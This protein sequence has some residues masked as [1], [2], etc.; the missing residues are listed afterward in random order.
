MYMPEHIR[1]EGALRIPSI[2]P[3]RPV[4]EVLE[5]LVGE[6]DL[7][8][9]DSGA[10]EDGLGAVVNVEAAVDGLG[11]IADRS[12]GLGLHVAVL[13]V[14]ADEVRSP[15][16]DRPAK[17]LGTVSSDVGDNELLVH[18]LLTGLGVAL[19]DGEGGRVAGN[20]VTASRRSGVG[21]ARNRTGVGA[22]DGTTAGV[23][24]TVGGLLSVV[25]AGKLHGCARDS[26]AHVS[27]QPRAARPVVATVVEEAGNFDILIPVLAA[28]ATNITSKSGAA[29]VVELGDSDPGNAD[30]IVF[31]GQ[32]DVLGTLATNV[33]VDG[34]VDEVAP[35]DEASVGLAEVVVVGV[36]AVDGGNVTRLWLVRRQRCHKSR[37]NSVARTVLASSSPP[38]NPALTRTVAP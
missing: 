32:S 22:P 10:L 14:R 11:S 26:L 23:V 3:L 12:E 2:N 38:S 5:G 31:R 8:A 18:P 4:R 36:P 25:A 7:A 19:G 24:D 34:E 17:V 13:A 15:R 29:S 6:L 20:E 33:L 30:G 35:V 21:G 27:I 9:T 37:N 28:L 16:G 1:E